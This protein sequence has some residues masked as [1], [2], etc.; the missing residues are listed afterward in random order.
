MVPHGVFC[1]WPFKGSG[2]D[3]KPEII[4]FKQAQGLILLLQ[5]EI[6]PNEVFR[7]VRE[8]ADLRR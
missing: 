1:R 3:E 6:L 2:S 5:R 4:S 8:L 7:H